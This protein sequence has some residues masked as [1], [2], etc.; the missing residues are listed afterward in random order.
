MAEIESTPHYLTMVATPYFKAWRKHRALT[1]DQVAGRTGIETTQLSKLENNKLR[2][3]QRHLE[4]LAH[5]YSCEP[6]D[7]FF[8][9]PGTLPKES[10][11]ELYV[12]RLSPERRS[13]ALDI[14]RTVFED[15]DQNAA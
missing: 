2:Y 9:P 12:K 5:A 15:P 14:L 11:F 3:S 7:L 8:P 10:E 1:Q 4:A 6:P 13:R